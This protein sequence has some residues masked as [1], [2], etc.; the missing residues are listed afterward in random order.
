MQLLIYLFLFY[1]ISFL[2]PASINLNNPQWLLERFWAVFFRKMY[3]INQGSYFLGPKMLRAE[4]PLKTIFSQS[5]LGLLGRKN[6]DSNGNLTNQ[7]KIL[8]NL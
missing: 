3:R 6:V 4:N 2:P 1:F 7:D 8:L 5:E